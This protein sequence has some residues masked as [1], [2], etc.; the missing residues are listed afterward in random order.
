MIGR[1]VHQMLSFFSF[2]IDSH[3]LQHIVFQLISVEQNKTNVREEW[4]R[5]RTC[6][7]THRSLASSNACCSAVWAMP[8][9]C[10]TANVRAE[11]PFWPAP[12][13]NN[14]YARV[15][16]RQCATMRSAALGLLLNSWLVR[17]SLR[18]LAL[19]T[20]TCCCTLLFVVGNCRWS[21]KWIEMPIPDTHWQHHIG[22]VWF[23]LT[24][25]WRWCLD[26]QTK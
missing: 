4:W 18:A 8:C 19:A 1:N 10:G 24:T 26:K 14:T 3:A 13:W 9:D 23:S 15:W 5:E 11:K 21:T 2:L 16:Q 22:N 25:F 6:Q 17:R 12:L 7:Q 20:P